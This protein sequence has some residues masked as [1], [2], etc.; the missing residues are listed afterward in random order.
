MIL[1]ETIKIIESHY[2]ERLETITINKVMAGIRFTAIELS[3]KSIGMAFSPSNEIHNASARINESTDI[4]SPGKI[5]GQNISL[6]LK[7]NSKNILTHVL[8]IAA[9]NALSSKIIEEKKYIIKK[10]TDPFSLINIKESH[11]ICMVGAFCTYI[12]KILS[13][14]K[15]LKVLE[16]E[17]KALPLEHQDLYVP[18]NDAKKVIPQAD[19][20]IITGA[21]LANNT[22]DELLAL[23][24]KNQKIIIVGPSCNI[25]PDPLFKR[26]VHILGATRLYDAERIFTIIA[27]G[28]SAYNLIHECAEKICILN[29]EF[30]EG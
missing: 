2:K 20:L 9:I 19:T 5:A 22:L 28:G 27:E 3:D 21:T 8:K 29:P 16:L 25:V 7:S 26:N 6:L 10:N 14:R 18:V 13:Q 12:D 24:N 15:T 4:F 11:T 23:T 30:Y 17:K 1:Q